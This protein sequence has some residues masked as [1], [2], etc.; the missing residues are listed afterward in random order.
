MY[1]IYRDIFYWKLTFFHADSLTSSSSPFILKTFISKLGLHVCP[2]WITL[3]FVR[4]HLFVNVI[5]H[6]FSRANVCFELNFEL[7]WLCGFTSLVVFISFN[8]LCNMFFNFKNNSI[9]VSSFDNFRCC[10]DSTLVLTNVKPKHRGLYQCI[11]KNGLGM[12]Y[13]TVKLVVNQSQGTAIV[14]TVQ[15]KP[16]IMLQILFTILSWYHAQ[17]L[18]LYDLWH[19]INVFCIWQWTKNP[20][21]YS[22]KFMIFIKVS[23]QTVIIV[24]YIRLLKSQVTYRTCLQSKYRLYEIRP[25]G[26]ARRLAT[27]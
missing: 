23:N 27:R 10:P 6:E 7:N 14:G 20:E 1:L 22:I 12:A 17:K 21:N 19:S 5:F 18:H 11:A 13:S 9:S 4:V 26:P 2:T 24:K 8:L 15:C 16:L 3:I 25:T